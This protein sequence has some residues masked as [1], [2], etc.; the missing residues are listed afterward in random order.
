MQVH[1]KAGANLTP[2]VRPGKDHAHM[3]PRIISHLKTNNYE[4]S[5]DALGRRSALYYKNYCRQIV[6]IEKKPSSVKMLEA[7]GFKF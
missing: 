7:H 5:T 4:N 1:R 6:D 2:S 3:A